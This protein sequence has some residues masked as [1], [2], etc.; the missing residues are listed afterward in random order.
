MFRII[1]QV[2]WRGG[3][4]LGKKFGALFIFYFITFCVLS[5]LKEYIYLT[6]IIRKKIKLFYSPEAKSSK[7]SPICGLSDNS[8]WIAIWGQ[9]TVPGGPLLTTSEAFFY[10]PFSCDPSVTSDPAD[11]LFPKGLF[12]TLI[13]PNFPLLPLEPVWCGIDWWLSRVLVVRSLCLACH[14]PGGTPL[15]H[16]GF[17]RM[18]KCVWSPAQPLRILHSEGVWEAE[19]RAFGFKIFLW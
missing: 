12:R 4:F 16:C 9:E 18:L 3:L 11:F 17:Q 15:P 1:K 14:V 5:Y 2:W 13:C 7:I 6:F 8:F 19:N 10:S